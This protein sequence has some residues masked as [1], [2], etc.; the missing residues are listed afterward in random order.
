MTDALF[1]T[2]VEDGGVCCPHCGSGNI[3]GQGFSTESGHAYQVID[4]ADCGEQWTDVYT[5]TS[6]TQE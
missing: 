4:C 6:A 2:Y 3:S 5:L 1:A